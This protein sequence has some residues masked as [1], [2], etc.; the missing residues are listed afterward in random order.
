MPI[1]NRMNW[2]F[3]KG[4]TSHLLA[5]FS[6]WHHN[7][8]APQIVAQLWHHNGMM[9]K[10]L[11]VLNLAKGQLELKFHNHKV[12]ADLRSSCSRCSVLYMLSE[13]MRRSTSVSLVEADFSLSS[14]GWRTWSNSRWFCSCRLLTS[15]SI[16]F[17]TWASC[18]LMTLPEKV[19]Q[20]YCM[21]T[22][23]SWIHIFSMPAL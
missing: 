22:Y 9:S 7:Q 6:L 1:T 8:M 21:S 11:H 14:R 19:T 18:D 3:D 23:F 10:S 15:F 4:R 17:S 16:V 5:D 20:R 2:P 12:I 13:L